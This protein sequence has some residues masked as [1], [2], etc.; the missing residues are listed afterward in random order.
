M[1]SVA[2][3][4]NHFGELFLGTGRIC[5]FRVFTPTLTSDSTPADS[6]TLGFELFGFF[7]LSRG[8][9]VKSQLAYSILISLSRGYDDYLE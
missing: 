2:P 8:N 5:G 1:R 3:W 6:T 7:P 9:V 4:E